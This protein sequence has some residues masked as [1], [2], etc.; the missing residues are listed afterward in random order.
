[1]SQAAK[2]RLLG[3]IFIGVLVLTIAS[4]G[5]AGANDSSGPA[6]STT[7]PSPAG[8][9]PGPTSTSS[10]TSQRAWAP[11]AAPGAAAAA[12]TMPGADPAIQ[13]WFLSVEKAKITF[14]QALFQAQRGIKANSAAAC[15]P[16]RRAASAIQA[17]LARL[18]SVSSPAGAK[19]ADA[20]AP[21][22]V[23]MTSIADACIKGDYPAAQKLMDSTGVPQQADTQA[24]IDEILDGG[25]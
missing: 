24:L 23:T 18:H 2:N 25:K 19:I 7:R 11:A 3:V 8:L 14:N 10:D 21:L 16:L 1:M 6:A 17:E 20:V 9:L 13:K 22:M 5:R 4:C 12:S 15:Q